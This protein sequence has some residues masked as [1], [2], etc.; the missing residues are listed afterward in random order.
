M[1][2][3]SIIALSLMLIFALASC[4]VVAGEVDKL[5]TEATAPLVETI[6]TLEAT[7][8]ELENAK[9]T[10]ET[11]KATL[12]EAKTKL[13]AEKAAL[14]ETKAKLE[15]DKAALEE[16]KA[17]LESE[18]ATLEEEMS[19]LEYDKDYEIYELNKEIADLEEYL[20]ASKNEID[21]AEAKILTLVECLK[22]NHVYDTVTFDFFENSYY[23]DIKFDCTACGLDYV[24]EAKAHLEMDYNTY[25]Y[26]ITAD[27]PIP[28][29]DYP[30]RVDFV[31]KCSHESQGILTVFKSYTYKHKGEYDDW[32]EECQCI[33]CYDEYHEVG[34]DCRCATCDETF[35]QVG[36][37]GETCA[38]CSKSLVVASITVDGVKQNYVDI[39]DAIEA[40]EKI[41]GATIVLEADAY[42]KKS[43]Y[44]YGEGMT[45][46]FNG[47]SVIKAKSA[48]SS[49]FFYTYADFTFK[50]SVGGSV[51]E[52]HINNC[53]GV[54]S[55]ESGKY[56]DVGTGGEAAT[57]RIIGGSIDRLSRNMKNSYILL[58]G[59]SI[60]M[61]MSYN[62]GDERDRIESFLADGYCYYDADG[63]II[64]SDDIITDDRYWEGWYLLYNVT[65]APIN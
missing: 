9:A 41:P 57:I 12:E 36:D 45:F 53:S 34:E 42:L 27:F 6:E 21:E 7:K 25:D 3:L 5:V 30:T 46:D 47:Y 18:K 1:K 52:A 50:D 17:K 38:I 59:G 8:T 2:K 56:G 48:T 32:Y 64:D 60:D 4:D 58:S 10:L 19:Q 40:A 44:I 31:G 62:R 20:D 55:I 16:T 26:Y 29:E 28:V 33:Y 37:D 65:V 14:E 43:V 15:S 24:Y 51:C 11:A 22:G 54:L 23:G 13:E 61:I 63:N 39:E 35:H 49:P